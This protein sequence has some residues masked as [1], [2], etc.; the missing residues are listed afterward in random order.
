MKIIA[1][2]GASRECPENTF[3]AFDRALEIGVDAIETDVQITRDGHC[4]LRHDDIILK[5]GQYCYINELT[6]EELL[7]IDLGQGE[8]VPTLL[9]FLEKY[10]GRL[11]L[12]LEAKDHRATEALI[13]CLAA[14]RQP[15]MLHVTSFLFSVIREVRKRLPE[16]GTSIVM[17]ALPPDPSSI[18]KQVPT[19]EI[20]LFR[21]FLTRELVQ[22]LKGNGHTVRA[23]TVNWPR[24]AMT[25]A[26]WGVDAVFTDDP[27]AMRN[28]K[29]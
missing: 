2:R 5:E 11:P 12:M 1:H 25:L 17:A 7:S 4:V 9:E 8:R 21:G 26:S 13:Q 18:F 10:E 27:R 23:Y 3:A 22:G 16:L 28:L 19:K 14:S 15:G 6:L 20:S 24:E 29:S